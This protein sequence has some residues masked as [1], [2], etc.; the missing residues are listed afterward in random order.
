LNGNIRKKQCD[1]GHSIVGCFRERQSGDL[2]RINAQSFNNLYFL[3]KI[4][5][6]V[7]LHLTSQISHGICFWNQ[8][9]GASDLLPGDYVK[10]WKPKIGLD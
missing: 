3:E 4:Q 5:L 8:N 1:S 9:V 7:R 6:L 2:S 10:E